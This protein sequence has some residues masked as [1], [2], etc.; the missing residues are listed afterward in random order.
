MDMDRL[1]CDTIC[2]TM[3]SRTERDKWTKKSNAN[4]FSSNTTFVCFGLFAI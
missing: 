2:D 4:N 1:L 3:L